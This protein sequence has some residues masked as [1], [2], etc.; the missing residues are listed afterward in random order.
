M[1][2]IVLGNTSI[3]VSRMCFG[4]LTI[5]PLQRNL[6]LAEGSS[7]IRT[8]LEAGVNFID[9]AQ[10]YRNYSYIRGH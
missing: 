1:W 5:G 9:T 7:L 6:P 10:L 3:K 4:S 8:A 2:N